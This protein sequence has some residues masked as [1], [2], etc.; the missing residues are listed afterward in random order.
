MLKLHA[1]VYIVKHDQ[2]DKYIWN[3]GTAKSD[4]GN[5]S[6]TLMICAPMQSLSTRS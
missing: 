5:S 3:F 2:T 6:L 4:D 1:L